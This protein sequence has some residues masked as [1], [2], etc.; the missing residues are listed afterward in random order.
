MI[1]VTRSLCCNT[2]ELSA[3]LEHRGDFVLTLL[4]ARPNDTP[5]DPMAPHLRRSATAHCLGASLFPRHRASQRT[6]ARSGLPSPAT[7]AFRART[8]PGTLAAADHC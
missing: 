7:Q 6:A 8:L 1:R 3:L 2:R 4:P 5:H